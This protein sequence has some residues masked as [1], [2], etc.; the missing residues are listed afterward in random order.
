MQ[1]LRA[2]EAA[3]TEVSLHAQHK[4]KKAAVQAQIN[5]AMPR[6][7]SGSFGDF[8]F[9]CSKK[10]RFYTCGVKSGITDVSSYPG[11]SRSLEDQLPE[12]SLSNLEQPPKVILG[13]QSQPICNFMY[14]GIQYYYVIILL[15][16]RDNADFCAKIQFSTL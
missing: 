5:G 10:P 13:H 2:I 12:N 14:V 7:I 15:R 3:L 8:E 16:L 4:N 11:H 1:R 6:V 9:A